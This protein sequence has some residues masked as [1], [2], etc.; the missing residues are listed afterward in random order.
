MGG[1]VFRDEVRA[2]D[3]LIEALKYHLEN[4]NIRCGATEA[5]G[6]LGD[7]S[8]VEPLFVALHDPLTFV[9]DCAANSLVRVAKTNSAEP[10]VNDKRVLE[11]LT[12]AL[13]HEDPDVRENTAHVLRNIG[14]KPAY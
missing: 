14:C 11:T 8:T 4:P 9:S 5:L 12:E 6:K 7:K 1:T 3:H 10:L 13:E 2:S